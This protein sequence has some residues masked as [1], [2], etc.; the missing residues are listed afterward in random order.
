VSFAAYRDAVK[1]GNDI[2]LVG[3]VAVLGREEPVDRQLPDVADGL[4]D[5]PN[6]A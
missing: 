6:A 3:L 1:K 5:P 4:R 2:D